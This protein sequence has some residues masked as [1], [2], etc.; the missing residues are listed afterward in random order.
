[1]ANMINRRNNMFCTVFLFIL[2]LSV[3]AQVTP[4]ETFTLPANT[5]IAKQINAKEKHKVGIEMRSGEVISF[6]VKENGVNIGIAIWRPDESIAGRTNSSSNGYGR[7]DITIAAD[8]AGL[9]EIV[10]ANVSDLDGKYSIRYE[11]KAAPDQSDIQRIKAE[12]QLTEASDISGNNPRQAISLLENS[13]SIWEELGDKYWEAHTR[14]HLGSLYARL[15]DNS[16]ALDFFK[17]ADALFAAIA[18][19]NGGA[20]TKNNMGGVYADTGN[21]RQA[22]EYYKEAASLFRNVG[23]KKGEGWVQNNIGRS[24]QVMGQ[25]ADAFRILQKA[26]LLMGAARDIGGKALVLNNIGNVYL[27]LGEI[28]KGLSYHIQVLPLR[29]Q[30]NDKRGEAI[31]LNNIGTAYNSLNDRENALK[32]FDSSLQLSRE[33]KDFR[34]Q[35]T[36]LNAKGTLYSKNNEKQKALEFYQEALTLRVNVGDL[37]AEAASWGNIASVYRDLGQNEN[38]LNYFGK[39]LSLR[40]IVKDRNGEISTLNNLMYFENSLNNY[41]LA[42]F[43]GKLAI[44]R[45]EEVREDIKNFDYETQKAYL[46]TVIRTYQKLA[47]ITLSQG[48]LEEAQQIINLSRDQQFFDPNTGPSGRGVKVALSPHE[49]RIGAKYENLMNEVGNTAFRFSALKAKIGSRQPSTGEAEELDKLKSASDAASERF[50]TFFKDLRREF[51]VSDREDKVTG[52]PDRPEMVDYLSLST[53]GDTAALYTLQGEDK[54]YVLLVTSGGGLKV[55]GTPI[56]AKALNKK[57]L[58]FYALL[59]S[60][61][62]DPRKLGRELYDVIFK[63]IEDE[64]KTQNIKKIMWSLDGNLRYV[65][66]SALWDGEKYLAER[67][68]TVI[69]TRSHPKSST[70]KLFDNWS[71][72]GFGSTKG[73]SVDLLGDGEKTD[74]PALSDGPREMRSIFSKPGNASA[75]INGDIFL[76]GAF[77]KEALFN[78]LKRHPP[79]VHISSHFLFRPGDEFRSFLLL[80]DGNILTL[81]EL[82][83]QQNLF[84]G[85]ELLTLSACNTAAQLSDAYGREIDNFAELAQRL[86][87]KTVMATLWQVKEGTTAL[88]ME[89]FYKRWKLAKLDKATA[90]QV[91]QLNLIHKKEGRPHRLIS[92]QGSA[93]INEIIVDEKYKIRFDN[94]KN[95][96]SHPYYWSPFVLYGN[97]R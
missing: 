48:R 85:V 44:L 26:L 78:A 14:N 62:Y 56:T 38:A 52:I 28:K 86:G 82:Q 18:D 42:V 3:S 47:D 36:T 51:Q 90:L 24:Y 45:Y 41:D 31:T 88:F 22:L 40:R 29:R 15:R 67:Y 11:K 50:Q 37:Q 96:L 43:Y 97:S 83:E 1:M 65:P 27:D 13:L 70:G 71:G 61:Q 76:D 10:V 95:P 63:P 49:S 4:I 30:L 12:K 5:E 2:S 58:Q 91:V 6:H 34:L 73:Q 69:F 19:E 94:N 20:I 68:E 32:F 53:H 16:K 80:G 89:D 87:A 17:S 39:S 23:N 21:P 79:I 59:Q 66:M 64:L 93:V 60:T 46:R 77:T 92:T 9:Y 33:L 35:A 84:E 75:Y 25:P 57:I 74:L 55:F 72:V 8:Q 81:S 7:E 54:F